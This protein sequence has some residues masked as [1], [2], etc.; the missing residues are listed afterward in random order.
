MTE[1]S[2]VTVEQAIRTCA[3]R[4]ADGVKVC[5]E[6][7]R[8]FLQADRDYDQAFAAAYL[9]HSGAA[10]EKRY[11][12]EINTL[13]EREVRDMFDAAYRYADRQAKALENELRAWQSVG[14]SLRATYGAAGVGEH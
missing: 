4:I 7:Y 1:I 5:D 11:A 10:H 2:P 8:L 14:A 6:R 9:D 12:A 13:R 3:N